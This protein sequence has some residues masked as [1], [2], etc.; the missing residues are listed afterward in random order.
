MVHGEASGRTAGV[1]A[2]DEDVAEAGAG[3]AGAPGCATQTWPQA[4]LLPPS[5]VVAGEEEEVVRVHGHAV[6]VAGGPAGALG[7]ATCTGPA[8]AS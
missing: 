1:R 2:N 8:A 5:V 7:R 4:P 6:V 3:L